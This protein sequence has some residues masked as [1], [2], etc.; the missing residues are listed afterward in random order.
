MP[1]PVRFQASHTIGEL[2]AS[3]LLTDLSEREVVSY[4]RLILQAEVAETSKISPRNSD[5]AK[6]DRTAVK[7]LR[8]LE[9]LKLIRIEYDAAKKPGRTVEVLR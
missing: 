9:E 5:I 8:R 1:K 7:T 6:D 3:S 4:M 2:A